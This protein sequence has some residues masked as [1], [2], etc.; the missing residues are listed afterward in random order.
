[1]S[2]VT[3]PSAPTVPPEVSARMRRVRSEGTGPEKAFYGALR[4]IG[5]AFETHRRDLP[6]KPDIVFPFARLAIFLDGD[7]WHGHQWKLRGFD[8]LEDQFEGIENNNY[9]RTKLSRNI[10]RDFRNTASLL[11]AGWRVLRF[12]SRSHLINGRKPLWDRRF[13]LLPF[14][15]TPIYFFF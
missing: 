4:R 14:R 2:S 13:A 6:G 9:W 5:F 15:K 7:L 3:V 1:M 11:D 10:E 12:W 8:S